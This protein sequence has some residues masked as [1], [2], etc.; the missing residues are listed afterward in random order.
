MDSMRNILVIVDPTAPDP[1]PAIDKAQRLAVALRADLELIA[2]ETRA[3]RELRAAR[4][5]AN[6]GAQRSIEDWLEQQRES[7][8][9][10]LAPKGLDVQS[11]IIRGDPLHE[12][13][14]A[15]LR[16]SPADLVI[17]DTHHHPLVRRTFLGNTDW[18]LIRDCPRAL[19]LTKPAPW[20][21]PPALA[22]AVDPR[23]SGHE[24]EPLDERILGCARSLCAAFDARLRVVHAYL[25]ELALAAGI[26]G[27]A[28]GVSPA[29]FEAEQAMQR[30]RIEAL[31]ERC[32]LSGAELCV[33][34]GAAVIGS[35][36][37]HVLER[38]PCDVLIV[39]APELAADL[40]F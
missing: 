34:M 16:D 31:L 22:A 5:L 7:L 17:K 4:G 30:G 37:E 14:I 33:E 19:L 12:R 28:L 9:R 20:A 26:A 29:E 27:T 11:A 6:A 36:A 1:Q 24:E 18:H 32:A 35:T 15:W 38:L 21:Q 3:V 40:P 13:I 25:P 2:C 8:A 23:G 39:R 10:A